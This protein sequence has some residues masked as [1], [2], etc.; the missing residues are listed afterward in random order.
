MKLRLSFLAII[1]FSFFLT[2]CKNG[3][4]S[5]SLEE[6]YPQTTYIDEP[7][8]LKI[9]EPLSP[10]H[11]VQDEFTFDFR[12][13]PL[14]QDGAYNDFDITYVTASSCDEDLSTFNYKT[15]SWNQIGLSPGPGAVCLQVVSVQSHL[16]SAKGL[17]AKEY[18]NERA[19]MKLRGQVSTPKVRALEINPDYFAIP[20]LVQ[21]VY[22]FNGLTYDGQSLWISSN[23][24]NKLYKVSL[25]GTILKEFAA[26]SGYPFGLAF[27]GQNLWLA[28]GTDRIFKLTRNGDILCQFSVPTDFPGGLTWGAN[29][30]WLTEY[31]GPNL[32]L[33]GIDPGVSCSAEFAVITDTLQT[34]G[35]GSWGLGWD[36]TYLLV[37]S[38][39]LYHLTTSG[40]VVRAYGLPVYYAK[41]IAWD[42]KAVWLLNWGPKGCA[43][44]DPVITRFKLR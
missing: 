9:S 44:G 14:I 20:I 29:K 31:E 25:S 22:D 38:D 8:L 40:A 1:V 17:N 3:S 6:Q 16:F 43:S 36:G 33:F 27:D 5:P 11:I 18:L 7:I 13:V 2:G 35:G 12:D 26:P 34:P 39:S 15:Q 41:D 24:S 19:Q 37:A 10:V 32:R 21:D 42:G 28:D 23:W 4:L 30:L